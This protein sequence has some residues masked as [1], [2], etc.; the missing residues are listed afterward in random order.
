MGRLRV[1]F[2]GAKGKMGQALLPGLRA[3]PDLEVVAEIDA[4]EAVHDHRLLLGEPLVHPLRAAQ[5]VVVGGR[6]EVLDGHVQPLEAVR[7]GVL[8]GRRLGEREHGAHALG[9]EPRPGTGT[10]PA[11]PGEQPRAHPAEVG[12][13]GSRLA[14]GPS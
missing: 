11:H 8:P 12:H 10:G 6:A 4:G 7:A 1:L 9:L 2:S 14:S 13:E 5:Q 3:A